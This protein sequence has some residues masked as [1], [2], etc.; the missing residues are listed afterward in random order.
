[1]KNYYEILEVNPKASEDII[2]KVYKIKVKQNHPDLFQGEEKKKAEEKTK[3]ITEAYDILSNKEKR[4]NYDLELKNNENEENEKFIKYESIIS[5]LKS[6][7]EYLKNVII[8]KNNII[9]EFLEN[10]SDPYKPSSNTY[11]KQNEKNEHKI[12]FHSNNSQNY[13][14]SILYDLKQLILKL[15]IFII[16]ILLL[17]LIFWAL[18]GNNIFGILF[19]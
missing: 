2:K 18:T 14:Y 15:A 12:N 16:I 11:Y 13:F 4:Q 19:K 1:M 8:S 7:N 17:L 9:N 3:E 5:S 6:E 10:E